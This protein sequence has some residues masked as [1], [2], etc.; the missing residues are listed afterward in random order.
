MMGIGRVCGCPI[1]PAGQSPA[2]DWSKLKHLDID[3]H[4]ATLVQLAHIFQLPHL[5]DLHIRNARSCDNAP[6]L[7]HFQN[8]EFKLKH[9]RLTDW[10]RVPRFRLVT[11]WW[12]LSQA[13]IHLPCW[14]EQGVPLMVLPQRPRC[15]R[16]ASCAKDITDI[17]HVQRR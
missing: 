1:T 10:E 5:E 6:G 13:G 9:L 7:K 12:L 3:V 11:S 16:K 17:D 14:R 8:F 4:R 15:V 2:H